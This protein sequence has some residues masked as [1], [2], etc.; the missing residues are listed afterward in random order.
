M[1][2]RKTKGSKFSDISMIC[3]DMH[4]CGYQRVRNIGLCVVKRSL[5]RV[6]TVFMFAFSIFTQGVDYFL[7]FMLIRGSNIVINCF[8]YFYNRINVRLKLIT[9]FVK[10]GF[11]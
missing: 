5:I 11:K 7:F 4:K 9:Y 6:I 10:T 1:V 3:S 8:M 2:L